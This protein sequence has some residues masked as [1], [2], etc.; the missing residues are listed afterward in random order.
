MQMKTTMRS[1]LTPVRMAIATSQPITNAGEDGE[2]RE[3]SCAV[4]GNVNWYN[5]Y[6]KRYEGSSENEI[7]NY[8]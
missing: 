2:K 8:H 1:H 4:G 3:P 6:G 5:H 7:Q